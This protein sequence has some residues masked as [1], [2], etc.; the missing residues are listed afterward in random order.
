MNICIIAKNTDKEA[1]YLYEEFKKKNFKKVFLADLA[2]LNI[3]VSNR[4]VG[5]SYKNKFDWDV[6]VIRPRVEDF[7][8]CYLISDIMKKKSA[9]LPTPQAILNCSNRGLMAKA[10]LEAKGTQPLSYICLSTESAKNIATR[11]KACALKLAKHG[12]KGVVLVKKSSNASELVDIFSDLDQP[13]CIQRFINGE[14]IKTLIV[15]EEIIAMREL[16]KNGEE[17]S[18]FGKREHIK[19]KEEVK[20]DLLSLSKYLGA[21][22]FEVD[23]IEKNSKY[24]I[25]DVSLTPNLEMYCEISGRNV[26]ALYADYILQ[27]Y[28]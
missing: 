2:K 22:L 18:N 6:C 25:I 12:G 4:G 16:P 24:Y 15:G 1:V 27:N 19:I 5:I 17:R 3:R 13:F 7:A 28:S 26:G 23:L 8:F 11:F 10:I 9:C 14:I 21:F 20:N